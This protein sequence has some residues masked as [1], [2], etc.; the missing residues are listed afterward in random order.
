MST[1]KTSFP[2]V[3]DAAFI[4]FS[5]IEITLAGSKIL[6]PLLVTNLDP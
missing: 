3:G 4:D 6:N 1:G 5:M 2:D